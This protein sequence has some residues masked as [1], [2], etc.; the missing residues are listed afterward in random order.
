[1]DRTWVYCP[2]YKFSYKG[3][4]GYMRLFILIAA[5]SIAFFGTYSEAKA[6]GNYVRYYNARFGFSVEVPRDFIPQ[7]PPTNNDGRVFLSEDGRAEIRV[8]AIFNITNQ[9]LSDIR[10]ELNKEAKGQITFLGEGESWVAATWIEN[11]W[12]YY[13]KRFITRNGKTLSTLSF[14]YPIGQRDTYDLITEHLEKTFLPANLSNY[15]E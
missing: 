6:N 12:I 11:E 2:H 5:I 1:M 14:T 15:R 3:R 7:P 13:K 4:L 9:T 10:A 8:S